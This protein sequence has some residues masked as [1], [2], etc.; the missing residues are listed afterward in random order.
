VFQHICRW[1]LETR[2]LES[3]R[4][5][6]GTIIDLDLWAG[7]WN[8]LMTSQ[9]I[10]YDAAQ[11]HNRALNMQIQHAWAL[12]TWHLRALSPS[13]IHNIAVITDSQQTLIYAAKVA[14]E[15]NLQLMLTRTPSPTNQ[16]NNQAPN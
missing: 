14:A 3:S 6:R 16:R 10:Y 9:N 4:K 15:R 5:V 8:G 13:G 12:M 2:Y 11:N 7:E 1:Q